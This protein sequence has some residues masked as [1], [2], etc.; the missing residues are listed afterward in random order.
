MRV[1]KMAAEKE[2]AA[3]EGA[4]KGHNDE[5]MKPHDVDYNIIAHL[6]RIPALL[7]VH[8][9]LMM[10]P[11]LREALVKALQAPELYEVCMAKHRLFT[12]P[13]FV[14]EITFDEEDNIIEDGAHNRPLYVEGNI[15]VA[16]LRRIL[17]DPG[18]A[19]NIL[20]VRSLK[21]AGFTVDDLESTDVMICGF[22]NQGK[23]TLGAITVKIQMSTF[24]FKVRFFVIEANTS[25]SA[26]LGRPWIHKY[27]V[28]PSTLHQ[29]L[30]FLDGNGTQ[31]RIAG[32][33]NPYTV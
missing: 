12:N 32:N 27:R 6:K 25:Y 33:T 1:D 9:A 26:L 10:V 13:L 16:H 11:S 19:V 24:S 4:L 31:Q 18:S 29:C 28:V 14:N 15:G 7:S 20:P 3:P 2:A 30:K 21:R 8:D 22:D 23:P 17:I 5:K